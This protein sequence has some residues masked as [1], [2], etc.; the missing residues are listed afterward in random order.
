MIHRATWVAAPILVLVMAGAGLGWWGY[1]QRLVR[2]SLVRN[3]EVRESSAFHTLVADVDSLHT[4]LGKAQLMLDQRAFDIHVTNAWRLAY[5]VQ[6]DL[7]HLPEDFMPARNTET[8]LSAVQ[9][10]TSTWLSEDANPTDTTVHHRLKAYYS[11]SGTLASQLHAIQNRM[12]SDPTLTWHVAERAAGV[13]DVPDDT[14]V[15]TLRALD[16]RVGIFVRSNEMPLTL[17]NNRSIAFQTEPTIKASRAEA[18]VNAWVGASGKESW[19]VSA[20]GRGAQVPTYHV[21]GMLNGTNLYATVSQH[22][23]HVLSFHWDR[24]P[25]RA[26]VD[27]VDAQRKAAAWLKSKGFGPVELRDAA[28][29]DNIGYFQFVPIVRGAPVISQPISVQV[30]LDNGQVIGYD[31]AACLM[32]PVKQVPSRK[33]TNAQLQ[34]QIGA[35][36]QVRMVKDVIVEDAHGHFQPVVEFYGTNRDETYCVTIN[37][38][39]GRE[40]GIQQLTRT[41]F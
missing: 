15:D 14:L 39:T 28:Q 17:R 33:Y 16:S 25:R 27:F 37:A 29:S 20:T 41:N 10:S 35:D 2:Q 24:S 7:N 38:H 13:K 18:K 5:G 9:H 36:L 6:K 8:F 19:R 11:E 21:N 3:A 22:G 26:D 34:K 23:G 31:G 12:V 30:A 40:M 1:N 4:E 32:H